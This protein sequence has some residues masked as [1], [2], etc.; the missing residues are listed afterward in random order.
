MKIEERVRFGTRGNGHG[1]DFR[2]VIVCMSKYLHC[3]C[4]GLNIKSNRIKYSLV[5]PNCA[6]GW[7]R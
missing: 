2:Y 1:S 5:K 7:V 3:I 4:L 6:D